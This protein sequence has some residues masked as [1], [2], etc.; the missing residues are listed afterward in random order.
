MAR[1]EGSG[2]KG[3]E[4]KEDAWVFIGSAVTLGDVPADD[5]LIATDE[6]R[7]FD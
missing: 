1:S 2:V 5:L 7:G 6:A 4:G 3:D